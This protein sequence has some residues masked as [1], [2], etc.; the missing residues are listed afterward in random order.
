MSISMGWQPAKHEMKKISATIE[1]YKS[2]A[3]SGKGAPDADIKELTVDSTIAELP[4]DERDIYALLENHLFP[5]FEG[6][7]QNMDQW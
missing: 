5:F 4:F 7:L 1:T 6:L 2:A 3:R